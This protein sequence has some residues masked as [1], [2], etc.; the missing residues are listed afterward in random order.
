MLKKD[1]K[2]KSAILFILLLHWKK[3]PLTF[4]NI[5]LLSSVEKCKISIHCQ[6]RCLCSSHG[7]LSTPA[8]ISGDGNTTPKWTHLFLPFFQWYSMTFL[9]APDICTKMSFHQSPFKQSL[10]PHRRVAV[11]SEGETEV[12]DA[13]KQ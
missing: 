5:W 3:T 10:T 1:V 6:V 4:T 2:R 7:Y 13:K 12:K 8:P 9:K 11:R